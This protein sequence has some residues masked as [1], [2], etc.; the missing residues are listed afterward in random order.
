MY[1][2]GMSL[3]IVETGRLCNLLIQLFELVACDLVS[4]NPPV[5][6]DNSNQY[7]RTIAAIDAADAIV[8]RSVSRR[9]TN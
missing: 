7:Y 5:W 4:T 6:D 2:V 1:Y 8:R 3:S 9:P